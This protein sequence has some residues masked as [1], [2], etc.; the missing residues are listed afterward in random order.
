MMPEHVSCMKQP[1]EVQDYYFGDWRSPGGWAVY[2]YGSNVT[3][4]KSHKQDW[5]ID[6]KF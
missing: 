3:W 5:G 4:S 2:T 6:I 1:W